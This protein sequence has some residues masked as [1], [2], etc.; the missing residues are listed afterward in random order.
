MEKIVTV[1]AELDPVT[2]TVSGWVVECDG[3]RQR[4]DSLGEASVVAR[5]LENLLK[6]K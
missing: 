3:L 6:G 5:N 4:C 2:G 1:R